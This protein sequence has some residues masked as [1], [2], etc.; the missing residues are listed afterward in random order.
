MRS[1]TVVGVVRVERVERVVRVLGV[2]GVVKVVGVVGVGT[3]KHRGKC[4]DSHGDADSRP[5]LKL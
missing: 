4:C 5:R 2:K 3:C 1:L